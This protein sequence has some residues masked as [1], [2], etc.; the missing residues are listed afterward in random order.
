M[1]RPPRSA[2]ASATA[3]AV[4]A[5]LGAVL[6]GARVY[7]PVVVPRVGVAGKLRLLTRGEERALDLELARWVA[8]AAVEERYLMIAGGL[9]VSSERAVRTLAVAI[10]KQGPGETE[11]LAALEDWDEAD[12]SQLGELY[13]AYEDLRVLLDPEGMELS[14]AEHA[15]I[16]DAVKKKDSTLLLAFGSKRLSA[17]LCSTADQP[18]TSATPKSPSSS[19]SDDPTNPSE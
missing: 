13:R 3:D 19:I 9:T 14:T 6:A 10:R 8:S 2:P 16:R 5:S 7:A 15:A 1:F 18:A 12:D 11:P 17:W 4:E